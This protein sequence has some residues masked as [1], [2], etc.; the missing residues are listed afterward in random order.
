MASEA[1]RLRRMSER[2]T[3]KLFERFK[4]E[5]IK[6]ISSTPKHILDKEI[7]EFKKQQENGNINLTD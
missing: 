2:Q 4:I 5:T 6:K 1:R 3:K 7:E